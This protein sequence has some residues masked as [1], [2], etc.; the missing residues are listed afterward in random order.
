MSGRLIRDAAYVA[1]K[2]L[3]AA[4]ANNNTDSFDLG[5]TSGYVPE[6]IEVEIA[7]P[8]LPNHTDSTK[9]ILITLKSSS[10]DSTFNSTS[11][12]VQLQVAGVGSTGSVAVTKRIRLPSDCLRYIR[13]NQ[14]VPAGDGDNTAVEVTYSLLF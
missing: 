6:N 10:D 9:T 13:F 4:A 7:V 5:S 1:T 8:A 11:P 2:F 14:L 3:P 12:L